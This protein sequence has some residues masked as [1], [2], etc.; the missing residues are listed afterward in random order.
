MTQ[1]GFVDA[2]GPLFE[3]SPWVAERTWSSRPFATRQDLISSL[4]REVWRADQEQQLALLR[5][6]PD[7]GTR[8][9]MTDHSVQEQAGAGLNQLSLEE[10][11]QFIQL[12]KLYTDAFQFP[13]IM[14]V[15][16][17]TKET[18][19]EALSHRIHREVEEERIQALQEVCKIGRFRLEA[20]LVNEAEGKR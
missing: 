7:L 6:H 16:G 13:F 8:V 2:F 19:R 18:I 5:A 12:N 4:E 20:L 11:E 14:A 3:H 17:Q 9:R 15:K 1:D 10:Y